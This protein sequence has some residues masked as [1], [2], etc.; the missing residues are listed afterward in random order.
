MITETIWGT[1]RVEPHTKERACAR[2]IVIKDGKILLSYLPESD[3]YMTPSGGL[4]EGETL[5]ECCVREIAE[6][7]GYIVKP[8]G[9][10]PYFLLNE[11]YHEYKFINNFFICD[12]TGEQTE[13]RLTEAE[14]TQ[15]LVL[16]WIPLEEAFDIFARHGD[17]AATNEDKRGSYLRDYTALLRA[18]EVGNI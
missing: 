1:N 14:K 15:S 17:Y 9:D 16:K 5:P 10:E 13:I 4:E 12:L 7:T 2:G 8:H 11:L 18:R 6:E 3:F